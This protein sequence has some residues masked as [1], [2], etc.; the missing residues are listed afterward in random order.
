M[1]LSLYNNTAALRSWKSYRRTYRMKPT[2]IKNRAVLNT[3][4]DMRNNKFLTDTAK[5]L[6]ISKGILVNGLIQ[7]TRTQKPVT[8]VNR[9]GT[10]VTL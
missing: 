10:K 5:K 7:A 1:S 6:G 2:V 3:A 4:I 9:T 8:F